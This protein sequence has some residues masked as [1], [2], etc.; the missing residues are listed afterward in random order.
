[1]RVNHAAH[2]QPSAS[3]R[4]N[5]SGSVRL[6]P[7][8]SVRV[9]T[10]PVAYSLPTPVPSYPPPAASSRNL[11]TPS[12]GVALPPRSEE[13]ANALVWL[14]RVARSIPTR[15]AEHL[16]TFGV[17]TFSFAFLAAVIATFG[18]S[19]ALPQTKAAAEQPRAGYTRPTVEKLSTGAPQQESNLA[20]AQSPLHMM[21]VKAPSRVVTINRVTA[22]AAPAQAEAARRAAALPPPPPPVADDAI[23]A[24]RE[25]VAPKAA[26][27]VASPPAARPV[28]PPA[29]PRTAPSQPKEPKEPKADVV[30]EPRVKSTPDPKP[31]T[32]SGMAQ[33]ALEEARH[34]DTSLSGH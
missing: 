18:G 1:V 4:V 24:E 7:S 5:P 28:T 13:Q 14:T 23:P 6:N 11:L 2:V 3:V 22:A 27:V 33:R 8:A 29:R 31:T 12:E 32:E 26:P 10:P 15:V 21:Q 17:A 19:D 25:P 9:S 16:V 30:T 20:A 34:E